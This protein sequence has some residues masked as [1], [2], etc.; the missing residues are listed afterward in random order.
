[1]QAQLIAAVEKEAEEVVK[2]A[3]EVEDEAEEVED[4]ASA[5]GSVREL[6]FVCFNIFMYLP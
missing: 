4:E 2:E 6:Q 3:E 1:M 5:L